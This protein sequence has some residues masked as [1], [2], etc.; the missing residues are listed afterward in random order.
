M[1][2]VAMVGGNQS[3]LISWCVTVWEDYVVVPWRL[4]SLIFVAASLFGRWPRKVSS[5]TGI[6]DDWQTGVVVTWVGSTSKN[7]GV[8]K[9]T[10][11]RNLG[12]DGNRPKK[13][14]S[15][16]GHSRA[17]LEPWK[18]QPHHGFGQLAHLE[19]NTANRLR[20][21]EQGPGQGY[22]KVLVACQMHS[23]GS[24]LRSSPGS[25]MGS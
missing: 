24:R 8:A 23:A 25:G 6:S 4:S 15:W 11:W 9:R 16:R 2:R 21:P 12:S 3:S 13:F 20:F 17:N 1:Q 14:L 18:G 10:R 22:S 19:R 5:C 7:A